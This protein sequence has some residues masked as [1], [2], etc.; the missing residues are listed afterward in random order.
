MPTPLNDYL[1]PLLGRP[2]TLQLLPI[3]EVLCAFF[4]SLWSRG[5]RMSV[6]VTDTVYTAHL[7]LFLKYIHL[8]L[9]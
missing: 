8:I 1:Y 3:S 9:T 7:I 6:L 4:H 2:H 5:L